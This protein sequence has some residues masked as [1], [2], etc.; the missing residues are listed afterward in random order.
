VGHVISL[1]DRA[2]KGERGGREIPLH[3]EVRA[4]LIAWK[5][6]E[7]MLT[8]GERAVMWGQRGPM[9]ADGLVN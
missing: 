5:L 7:G 8:G 3:N 2:T 4:A 6:E 9:T 1:V